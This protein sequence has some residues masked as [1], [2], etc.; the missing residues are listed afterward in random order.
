[1]TGAGLLKGYLTSHQLT[2]E[3]KQKSQRC[4]TPTGISRPPPRSD[5]THASPPPTLPISS[6]PMPQLPPDV[7]PPT[8]SLPVSSS[9]SSLLHLLSLPLPLPY[10]PALS[11]PA[12]PH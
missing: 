3:D 4:Q 7:Y 12:S 9:L 10:P 2:C 11:L 8:L 6:P 5:N 1:M